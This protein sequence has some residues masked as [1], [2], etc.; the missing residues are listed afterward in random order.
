MSYALSA[1]LQA[2]VF[3]T[4]TSDTE[5][6]TLTG[7][8]VHDEMPPGPVEGTYVSLGT[9]TVRDLSDKTHR[10]SEHRFVVSVISD[11]E[12][13]KTGKTVAGRV[14]ELLSD[15]QTV[16]SRGHL[17]SQHF[18]SARAR[19]VRAGQTR[20]IDLTFRAVVEDS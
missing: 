7:G 5:L 14:T 18:V 15:A 4:L 2:S 13:F 20:R 8:A 17:V 11:A 16:L 9:E 10:G 1:A 12:G 6:G 3:E 19:R